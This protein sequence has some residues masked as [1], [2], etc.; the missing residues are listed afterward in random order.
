L[1]VYC[2]CVALMSATKATTTE[3]TLAT[4]TT[5]NHLQTTSSACGTG[6]S[7]YLSYYVVRFYWRQLIMP[8]NLV[9]IGDSILTNFTLPCDS[10]FLYLDFTLF[11]LDSTFWLDSTLKLYCSNTNL[12]CISPKSA[13]GFGLLQSLVIRLYCSG[14]SIFCKDVGYASYLTL[15]MVTAKQQWLWVF[16]KT[17]ITKCFWSRNKLFSA[18]IRESNTVFQWLNF[19]S[20]QQLVDLHDKIIFR[21]TCIYTCLFV[22]MIYV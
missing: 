6:C 14:I 8:S 1:V 3:T 5:T 18:A 9:K 4:N 17:N 19:T 11:R 16:L 21:Y 10:T 12:C 13:T 2:L 20:I 22:V 15:I 7:V